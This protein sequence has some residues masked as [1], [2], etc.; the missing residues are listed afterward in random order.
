LLSLMADD[1]PE[2]AQQAR[3][4]WHGRGLG[5]VPTRERLQRRVRKQGAAGTGF[6]VGID[7]GTTNS[8]IGVFDNDDVRVIPNA[9]GTLSTPSLRTPDMV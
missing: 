8:A 7:F 1:D 5:D 3:Q 2:V 6:V 4:L 9:Q